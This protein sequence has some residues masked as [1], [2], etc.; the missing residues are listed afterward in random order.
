MP[1]TQHHPPQLASAQLSAEAAATSSRLRPWLS[2]P[3]RRKPASV[4]SST[5]T[6]R[7]RLPTMER[8]ACSWSSNIVRSFAREAHQAAC[9]RVGQSARA[10]S[11]PIWPAAS[12]GSRSSA[13]PA[14]FIGTTEPPGGRSALAEAPR[15]G[16][17]CAKDAWSSALSATR[18][19]CAER[20]C[21]RSIM[22]SFNS[23]GCVSKV[24]RSARTRWVALCTWAS[25]AQTSC[26]DTAAAASCGLAAVVSS[27]S[28]SLSSRSSSARKCSASS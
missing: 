26:I 6:S 20:R 13:R 15:R 9:T 16:G 19:S 25:K 1:P 27:R 28:S 14:G 22:S 5:S 23:W 10:D 24:L 17:R 8:E 18:S 3:H 11:S 7:R 21:R 4:L 12:G 2:G